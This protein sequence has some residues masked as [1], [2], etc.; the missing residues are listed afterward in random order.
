MEA[1]SAEGWKRLPQSRS[2]RIW[3]ETAWGTGAAWKATEHRHTA[4]PACSG[5]NS[6]SSCQ[7]SQEPTNWKAPRP[8]AL[9]VAAALR[10]AA[11][12]FSSC[13]S[14]H[15]AQASKQ[16][17]T[18]EQP[19]KPS[20]CGM[21]RKQKS[22]AWRSWRA[23]TCSRAWPAAQVTAVCCTMDSPRR[24]RNSSGSPPALSRRS[25]SAYLAAL[26][27]CCSAAPTTSASPRSSAEA[28]WSA[29]PFARTA[30][31]MKARSARSSSGRCSAARPFFSK[32]ARMNSG[33]ARQ[34]AG[35]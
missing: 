10:G 32:A 26:S 25:E 3:N 31:S 12:S 4:P 23:T 20:P 35:A 9:G 17:P 30:P 22:Q 5:S 11:P 7:P 19:Q 34:A 2:C 8:T 18:S 16:Q 6:S 27:S 24:Q 1:P 21:E 15:S 14:R 33:S 13:D 28:T 29:K